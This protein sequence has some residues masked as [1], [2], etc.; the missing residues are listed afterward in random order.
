[1]NLTGHST[2]SYLFKDLSPND[3]MNFVLTVQYENSLISS[4]IPG[5]TVLDV[6]TLAAGKS[7]WGGG[8]R[9]EGEK[10]L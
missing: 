10:G 9:E 5:T 4:R 7:G 2:T 8:A 1:M 6:T 3:R